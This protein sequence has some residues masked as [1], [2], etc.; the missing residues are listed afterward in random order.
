MT[1][2]LP[3]P[4][5]QSPFLSPGKGFL[6]P[7]TAPEIGPLTGGWLPLYEQ[8]NKLKTFPSRT[9]YVNGKN[10]KSLIRGFP[11]SVYLEKEQFWLVIEA[12]MGTFWFIIGALIVV[13]WLEI[14]CDFLYGQSFELSVTLISTNTQL[15]TVGQQ[16]ARK[17]I[18]PFNILLRY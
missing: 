5:L 15:I 6:M 18:I 11:C 9:S 13:F 12:L 10:R 1:S 4:S 7:Q 17:I 2:P 16:K 3:S 8:T 14:V